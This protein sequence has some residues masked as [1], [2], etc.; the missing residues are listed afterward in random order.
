M[1]ESFFKYLTFEKRYSK[2]TIAAYQNDLSQF[3][4]FLDKEH[5]G[6]ANDEI[7]H[8]I[9]RGWVVQMMDEGLDPKSVNRKISSLKAYFG[10]LH[11]RGF[12][13]ENPSK[14]LQQLKTKKDIPHFVKEDEIRKL[15]DEVEFEN[16]F[17]GKRDK[18]LIEI[19]YGTGMRLA[20]MIGLKEIDFNFYDQSLKVLGKRNKERIIPISRPLCHLIKD[21]LNTKNDHFG[22]NAAPEIVVTNSGEKAYPML[23]YRIIKKYLYEYSNVDKKSPHVLRH[24][25]ATHLLDK[26][27]DINAV[28]E[29]LGHSSLAATQVYT[30]NS[31][32]KLKKAFDQ[33]HPKA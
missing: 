4:S 27:A 28:K 13:P 31:L 26:G 21:Y 1:I 33:A 10:F 2:H 5:P 32:G 8:S 24:T 18:L 17:E 16:S 7:N 23:I 14:R 11:K 15:L 22:G 25:F 30:H 20:E 12:L 3:H 9:L 19:F 6:I 29:I